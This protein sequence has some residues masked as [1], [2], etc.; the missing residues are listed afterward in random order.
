[1][2]RAGYSRSLNPAFS[3]HISGQIQGLFV[4]VKDM[5]T[6]LIKIIGFK[7]TTFAAGSRIKRKAEQSNNALKQTY[8]GTPPQFPS[9]VRCGR[10]AT[11]EREEL[12][13]TSGRPVIVPLHR[14]GKRGGRAGGQANGIQSGKDDGR[15]V[16]LGRVQVEWRAGVWAQV[17]HPKRWLILHGSLCHRPLGGP[18]V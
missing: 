17:L 7:K 8:N 12:A 1:M 4:F 14:T 16:L 3:Q 2:K 6:I 15:G 9:K 10:I 18:D 13:R 11:T 5:E